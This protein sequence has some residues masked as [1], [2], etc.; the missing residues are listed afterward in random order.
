MSVSKNRNIY[1]AIVGT[2]C[3]IPTRAVDNAD[4]RGNEF[5]QLD[6]EIFDKPTEMIIEKFAEITEIKERKYVSDDL[7]TS[8]ISFYAAKEALESSGTDKESLDYIIVAHNFGDINA[9]NKRSDFVPSIAS[10]VKHKLGIENPKTVAYDV[11][12]GCPGWLQCL[13][14]ADYYIKSGDAKRVLVIGADTLS[15]ISDPHDR[16]SMLYADG[17]GAVI[18]EA[19]I[20]EEPVGILS[21]AARTDTFEFAYMLW[22]GASNNPDYTGGEL[23]LKMKGHKLYE[24]ALS[25]VPKVVGESLEK[26]GLSLGNVDKILIYQ[27]NA[28]MDKAIL[29]RLFNTNGKKGIP[30]YIMPMIIARFGNSSVATLPTLFDLL[31]KGKVEN[32]KMEKGDVLVFASVGAGMNINSLVYKMP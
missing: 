19:R 8:D 32:Y 27:A 30:E 22:M 6:G 12:F 5:Y 14:Q 10:R 29:K 31:Q 20:S 4:F 11:C 28:K 17:A 15:R 21:H 26:A 7:V 1:S 13:I 2:G 24:Y 25:T 9:T 3:Y 16:D 23:F 18:V